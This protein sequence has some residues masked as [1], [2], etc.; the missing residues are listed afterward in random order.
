MLCQQISR[1]RA[2]W[3]LVA[4][5][6]HKPEGNKKGGRFTSDRLNPSRKANYLATAFLA[7]RR[8]LAAL[9]F[10]AFLAVFFLTERLAT[11][12]AA[13]RFLA[14]GLAALRFLAFLAVVMT[15]SPHVLAVLNEFSIYRKI[16]LLGKPLINTRKR[17]AMIR[18]FK[19]Y[20]FVFLTNLT[21]PSAN[22]NCEVTICQALCLKT[23]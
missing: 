8:F 9:R 4:G 22:D 13:L 18:K 19:S 14:T 17:L 11:F 1:N 6:Y 20:N 5:Q 2:G 12:F 10:G 16:T 23:N 15:F 3:R 7:L 21:T